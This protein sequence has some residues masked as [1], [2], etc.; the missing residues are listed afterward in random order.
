[1][2]PARIGAS[3][4]TFDSTDE[5]TVSSSSSYSPEERVVVSH[6]A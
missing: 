4:V 6:V 2:V 3:L 1:M 5:V